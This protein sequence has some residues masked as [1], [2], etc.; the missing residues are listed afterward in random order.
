MVQCLKGLRA[1]ATVLAVLKPVWT[2][3]PD[4][5]ERGA[6]MRAQRTPGILAGGQRRPAAPGELAGECQ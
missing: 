5:A 4:L 6:A 3:K 2:A 1:G